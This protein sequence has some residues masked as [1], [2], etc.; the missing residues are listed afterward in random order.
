MAVHGPLRGVQRGRAWGVVAE[1]VVADGHGAVVAHMYRWRERLAVL[2]RAGRRAVDLDR[3]RPAAPAVAG[4]AVGD[5]VP[6]E[7]A[8]LEEREALVHP[9]DVQQSVAAVDRCLRDQVTAA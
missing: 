9:D 8:G 1:V 3:R 5:R 6:L 4:L 2:A 7:C